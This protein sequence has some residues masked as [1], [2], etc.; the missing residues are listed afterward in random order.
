MDFLQV[1]S[2]FDPG[3]ILNLFLGALASL[4]RAW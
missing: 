2:Q 3:W 1:A 4:C